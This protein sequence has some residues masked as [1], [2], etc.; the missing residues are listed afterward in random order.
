M[1]RT[2]PFHS[3]C[4][5]AP[6]TLLVLALALTACGGD[7]TAP[8]SSEPHALDVVAGHDLQ[9]PAGTVLPEGPTVRVVDAD[10]NGLAGVEVVFQVTD[11]DGVVAEPAVMTDTR[12][13]ARG[14]WVLGGGAGTLQRLRISAASLTEV[15][16]AQAIAPEPGSSYTGRRGYI[17]YLP[18]SL[19]V[20]LTAPHGG[21]QE[22][23]EIPDR[24]WG[25]TV[26]DLH[27][28]ELALAVR[29]ALHERT[30]AY[31]HLVICH[32]DRAKLDANRDIE[33]AAQDEWAAERAWWEYHAYADQ[34]GELVEDEFGRG[35]YL[36]I[37]G[38]GHDV[39]RIELGY[40]LSPSELGMSDDALSAATMVDKSSIGALVRS[41]GTSLA[42]LV[43]GGASLGTL[44]SERGFPT[45]PSSADPDPGTDP[46]FTG[47]YS[48][49]RHGSRNGGEISGIQLEHNYSGVRDEA[50]NRRVYADALAEAVILYIAEHYGFD[51]V[52]AGSGRRLSHDLHRSRVAGPDEGSGHRATPIF[53]SPSRAITGW[54]LQVAA[55]P[56][57]SIHPLARR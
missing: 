32:L 42:A 47:G 52:A 9:A 8:A 2:A 48:T 22:P 33:E 46:Y 24:G 31:P 55:R 30:G 7:T 54:R 43:R 37:H 36:D 19:P 5:Q 4:F 13:E 38:H 57:V 3:G 1:R 49:V 26:T 18:G 28:R 40:L 6:R 51:L 14:T 44:L 20:I 53:R 56:E 10:G 41:S 25:T 29:D 21:D 15:L 23:V 12:G 16:E 50:S 17:E 11:G 45:V 27:T 39:Q 34:A 35:L